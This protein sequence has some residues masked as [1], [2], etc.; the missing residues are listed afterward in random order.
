MP[1]A[2]AQPQPLRPAQTQPAAEE[3]EEE[4]DI[5]D[6]PQPQDGID[7][8]QPAAV[9]DAATK[10]QR[11][12]VSLVLAIGTDLAGEQ[13]RAMDSEAALRVQQSSDEIAKRLA[14]EFGFDF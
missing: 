10:A 11:R 13:H 2:P 6:Q 7:D 8:A 5:D 14:K 4:D 3:A 12:A 1:A 9:E